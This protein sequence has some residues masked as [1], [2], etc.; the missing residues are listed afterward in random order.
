MNIH[1]Q[2]FSPWV[3]QQI[4]VRQ[5][6]LGNST[7]LTNTNLLYQN[8]KTPWLRLAS[9]VNITK[10]EEGDGV[11][12]KLKTLGFSDEIL[13]GDNVAKNFILQGGSSKIIGANVSV[14][15]GT[16]A[17][18]SGLNSSN[19]VF[20]G[21]Y[22][23]G[24]LDQRGFAPMPGIT[25]ATVQY[26]NNGALSKATVNM[27]CFTRNQLAL[28]DALYMRPGYNLLLEF[29]WSSYLN[30]EGSL[31]TYDNF[32]SPALSFLFNPSANNSSTPSHFD[33][34]DLVQKERY[35]KRGNY[36]GVFG[37][38]ANFNWKF[39]P[40]GSYDCSVNL[41]GMGD[42]M[43]SLKCNIKLPTKSDSDQEPEKNG[44]GEKVIPPIIANKT[45]TTLNKVL[46]GLYEKTSGDKDKDTFHNVDIKSM[47]IPKITRDNKGN[48][49]T[50]F[51]N[52]DLTINNGMLSVQ[53][54]D[55]DDKNN[56]SP[57]AY[58]TFGTLLA[59]IQKHLLVYNKDGVPLFGFD[60]DF[61][62]IEN[63]ENY[64]VKL[65]GQFSGNPLKCLIPYTGINISEITDVNYPETTLN[66][67]ML[68]ISSSWNFSTYLGRLAHIYLNINNI[69]TLLAETPRTE[70]GSLSLLSFLN[71]VIRSFSQSLGGIN[72]ISIKVDEVTGQVKFIEN[73]PQRL[74]K[75]IANQEFARINTF[76]VKPDTEG[77]FVR[78]IVMGGELG[79]DYASMIVIGAQYAGNKLSVNATG[80]SLYNKGLVDRVIPQKL[81]SG[82]TYDTPEK[83]KVEEAAT[84][85]DLWN[86]SIQDDGIILDSLFANIYDNRDFILEDL[87][88]LEEL[89]YNYIHLIHGKL[90]ELNQIQAPSFLP[91]NLSLD[92]DG[93][94][95]IK[96]F[97]QFRIDDG[98]L[99][100]SYG[101]NGV[102]LQV[103]ALNHSIT[104][105]SWL[106]QID[107]QAVP[108]KILAD[109][110]ATQPV[111][112]STTTQGSA[113]GG[114]VEEFDG[115]TPNADRLRATLSSLGYVEKGT[116]IANGGDIEN[117][118]ADMGIQVFS[119]IKEV[120]PS[121]SIKV[122][123]GNDI[124]HKGLSYNSRH[125]S[126]RGLDF[127]ITPSTNN[128]VNSIL[129]VLQGF[130]AGS[131]GN[132]RFLNEYEKPT[133]QASG[134]H[135]H[136]SY[137]AG[138]EGASSLAESKKLANEGLITRYS[139]A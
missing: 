115:L 78:N 44:T 59:L 68:Q 116:E 83:A 98:V 6:S 139:L 61:L 32:F 126:G 102:D 50:T 20:N 125:K 22:G 19:E 75:E 65:P 51:T 84:I 48:I 112:S 66:D 52:N 132:F 91:F 107:T 82:E 127:V 118:T 5:L 67:T 34:L 133:A 45:K 42:M 46:F 64:I 18:L 24:G 33:V 31:L 93:I 96:L 14:E 40:D 106:T 21:A 74:D 55:T 7:N 137:G 71:A 101:E 129:K 104:P 110:P 27:K 128:D 95:G 123:G 89:N 43:E 2:P 130:A 87:N 108:R 26:Y 72:L 76:G 121:I 35:N 17:L 28:M 37:K 111:I 8:S 122:T 9:S 58:I 53:D 1:G 54:V 13:L 80:F 38:I 86:K 57:Q 36:E 30:D 25:G 63:D 105:S 69:A 103:K 114:N 15:E 47:P 41:T 60:V 92:L 90:V 120:L 131:N 113:G 4:K 124:F 100:P 81:N 3:T 23:W 70:D 56:L 117:A 134:R 11:F 99:P 79:P 94:S 138:T 136:I 135:F 29:G 49:S 85:S 88:C 16:G 77:S 10:S 97:E 39:N 62:N 109:I 73:A 119:K 12:N